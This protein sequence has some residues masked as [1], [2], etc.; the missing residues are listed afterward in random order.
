[1]PFS[2]LFFHVLFLQKKRDVPLLTQFAHISGILFRFF[3]DAVID[4]DR[5]DLPAIFLSEPYKE[6]KKADGVCPA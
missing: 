4:M 5:C 3:S 6:R 2:G 1:M